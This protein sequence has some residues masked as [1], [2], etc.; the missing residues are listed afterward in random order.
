MMNDTKRGYAVAAALALALTPV[1]AQGPQALNPPLKNWAAPLYWA[2]TPGE[3]ER[4]RAEQAIAHP[5]VSS[6]AIA[7]ATSIFAAPGPMTFIAIT[8]CRVMD[9][10]ASQPFTG[11]FG[12]PSLAANVSRQVPLPSSATCSI[13][14]NAGAYSLNITVVPPGPLSFLSIWPAG[15]PYPGVSTLND[16]VAGGVIAN[17]A[18]VVAG[19]SGAIQMFAGN[20]T[21]VIIDINGYYTTPTDLSYNTALGM[22]TLPSNTGTDNTAI[23]GFALQHNSGG[24]LNTAIGFD[25]LQSNQSGYNNTAVGASALTNNTTG[26]SNTATGILALGLNSGG[27]FNTASGFQTLYSNLTGTYNTAS[28]A[29]AMFNSTGD[30]NTATGGVALQ[31]NTTG[32]YNLGEGYFSLNSNTSG[33]QN[34]A[35]GAGA[36]KSNTTGTNNIAVGFN[37]AVSVANG[38]GFN[39]HIG[40]PGQPGDDATIRIGAQGVQGSAYVAGIFGATSSGG[41]EVFVNNVGQLGTSPSSRRFKEQITDMGDSSGKLFQLRPVN[42]FYKPEYDDGSHLL[43][44]GLIA[45]EVAKIYPEMVAYDDEGQIH[46]VRYQLLAP[47]LLNEVQK[48]NA[49]I[50][51]QQEENRKLEDRLA[52]LEALLLNQTSAAAADQ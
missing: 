25:A 12:P 10:R 43:Q 17:A 46:S 37:A 19:T 11:A 45:E 35:V 24:N 32:Y 26:A 41:S 22:S 9:T 8:P 1:Y 16:P 38:N 29:N 3:A 52:A 34:T 50:Q 31:A 48:Q 13:P 15:A 4:Q 5:S 36:L 23:G 20:P 18:I 27:G 49:Q 33:F 2:P 14:S 28:G 6:P 42:F 47:M 30:Y 7:E 39:I 51:K 40:S 21:D 44:Y